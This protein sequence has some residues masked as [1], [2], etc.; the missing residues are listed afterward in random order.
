M[1]G[2]EVYIHPKCND[3][4]SSMN[5]PRP[6]DGTQRNCRIVRLVTS[7]LLDRGV[8]LGD[9]PASG[10]FF[11]HARVFFLVLFFGTQGC[12]FCFFLVR[13]VFFGT[14]FLVRKGFFWYFFWYF[15]FGMQ[16]L[17]RS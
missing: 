5:V 10:L 3:P 14:F 6:D 13:K 1:G 7:G 11:C 12:F 4:S 8:T 9:H 15:F 2:G 16:G 17:P